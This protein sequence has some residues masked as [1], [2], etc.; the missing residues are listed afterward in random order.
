MF[1]SITLYNSSNNYLQFLHFPGKFEF[2]VKSILAPS[3]MTS[4]TP[5]AIQPII[6]TLSF[7]VHHRLSIKG[8]IFSKYC[9]SAKIQ[10]E[11]IHRSPCTTVGV[12]ISLYVRGLTN[13]HILKLLLFRVGFLA[14]YTWVPQKFFFNT[15]K[16]QLFFFLQLQWHSS[17]TI[18]F[19]AA[20]NFVYP[21]FSVSYM[22]SKGE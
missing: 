8:K 1:N 2:L 6:F 14:S 20:W 13:L 22:F 4:R 11:S 18:N 19:L 17:A 3:W 9:N 5:A 15:D 16:Y 7:R 12:W 21:L 10:G